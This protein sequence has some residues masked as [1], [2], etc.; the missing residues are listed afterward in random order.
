MN[1]IITIHVSNTVSGIS[2]AKCQA[3]CQIKPDDSRTLSEKC[4]K[5]YLPECHGV[6]C[7]RTCRL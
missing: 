5:L 3:T 4:Y 6:E 1:N 7:S 2:Q